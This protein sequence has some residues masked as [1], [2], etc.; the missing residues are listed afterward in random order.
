MKIGFKRSMKKTVLS[1]LLAFALCATPMLMTGCHKKSAPATV[2]VVERLE[3]EETNMILTL[4][5]T[6]DLTASYNEI[7]NGKLTWVSSSPSVASVDASGR[8]EAMKVG[9]ATITARYGS[10]TATCEIEVGLSSNV[11]TILFSLLTFPGPTF[12]LLPPAH[13]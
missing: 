10:K 4:G 5:D 11:P 3:L 9:Y 13:L 1:F 2:P 7:E 12:P 6:V 8:V